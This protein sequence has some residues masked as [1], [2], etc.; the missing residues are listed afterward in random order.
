MNKLARG[1]RKG[2]EIA[3]RWFAPG[4]VSV[5]W[6]IWN[7]YREIAWFGAFAGVCSTFTGVFT[8]RLGGSDVLV[9]LLTSL[10]ALINIVWQIPAARLIER[11]RNMRK[12]ILVSGFFQR[13]PAL[14]LALVPVFL[15]RF[16]A[17][18][19]VCIT[20]LGTIPSAVS[21]VAFTVMLA[22]V[23]EP[24]HRA[25]VI[26]VRRVLFSA[27]TTVVV[28][29][30]GKTLDILRFPTSYQLIFALAFAAS[31]LS[32][33]YLG[34]IV[35]PEH[36]LPRR[37]GRQGERLGLRRSLQMI[38]AQRD[39]A[40]FALAS[41]LCQWGLSLP[42]PL[43]AIYW[44]RTLQISEGW[45]GALAMLSSGITMVAYYAW[46]RLAQRRGSRF[47]LLLGTLG[48]CAYPIGTALST[49]MG[50]LLIVSA[51]GGIV[52]P[53]FNLGLLNSLLEVTPADRRAMYLA[54]FNTLM[55]VAAFISPLLGTTL[56]G[57][58]GIRTALMIGG[59]MRLAGFLA[60]LR[61]VSGS[62]DLRA[63]LSAS[64]NR[65]K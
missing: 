8:L 7:L 3:L 41:F 26:S 53:A 5:E 46:G 22:D 28:I 43:Y 64:S 42:I 63:A 51:I 33:H 39:F 17:A 13:L 65:Q 10:P 54:L 45:V 12:T 4:E 44:V 47:V 59:A 2:R 32:L 34:C 35:I 31:L 29:V 55:N 9:G 16:Q 20:A 48:L 61:L 14:L 40:R 19:V 38:L 56:A 18:A 30:A 50:P 27:V 52:S 36:E 49:H 57:W 60:Y 21:S 25:H 1:L 6:N 15:R 23:V 62:F 24:R 37:V 11:Q 58:L